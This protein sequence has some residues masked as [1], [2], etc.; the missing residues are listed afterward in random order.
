MLDNRRYCEWLEH[1]SLELGPGILGN[2]FESIQ[3]PFK[4]IA[5][6]SDDVYFPHGVSFQLLPRGIISKLYARLS[7]KDGIFF[8]TDFTYE[9]GT[10]ITNNKDKGYNVPLNFPARFYPSDVLEFGPNKK[11]QPSYFTRPVVSI[12]KY[13]PRTTPLGPPPSLLASGF[14]KKT[15][16]AV[17]P[18]THSISFGPPR[19]MSDDR[20]YVFSSATSSPHVSRFTGDELHRL[21]DYKHNIRNIS[22][23]AHNGGVGIAEIHVVQRAKVSEVNQIN[24]KESRKPVKELNENPI[25]K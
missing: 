9:Q 16:K 21:M 20:S 8:V 5:R 19:N 11:S 3:R 15:S 14:P 23:I 2:I 7:C 1:L 12:T 17:S 6:I 18:R 25:K 4:T 13:T 10:W 24:G 22:V